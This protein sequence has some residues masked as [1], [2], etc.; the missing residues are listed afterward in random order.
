MLKKAEARNARGCQT[1]QLKASC[2]HKD[3][4]EVRAL[5]LRSLGEQGLG[6][7]QI[8]SRGDE[9]VAEILVEVQGTAALSTSMEKAIGLLS[10]DPRVLRASWKILNDDDVSAV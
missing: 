3:A 2:L 9:A 10:L 1:C 7:S 4:K 5:L 6:L 8:A